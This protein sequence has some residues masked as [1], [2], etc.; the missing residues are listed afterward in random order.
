MFVAIIY[1]FD[2]SIMNFNIILHSLKP[3]SPST[4]HSNQPSKHVITSLA[5]V[6]DITL[7]RIKAYEPIYHSIVL[8][9]DSFGSFVSL[10][11]ANRYNMYI[12]YL[13]MFFYIT[14]DTS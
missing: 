5:V 1:N 12:K 9:S 6:S 10:S 8:V 14:N 3:I 4:A 7:F 11:I 2:I 13:A